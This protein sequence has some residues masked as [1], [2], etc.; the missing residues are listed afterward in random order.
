MW[1]TRSYGQPNQRFE[2]NWTEI[3]QINVIP[4]AENPVWIRVEFVDEKQYC[5]DK[6]V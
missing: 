3:S 5:D 6:I 4:N 1:Y 2:K